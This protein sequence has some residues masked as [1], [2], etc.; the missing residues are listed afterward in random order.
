M[1]RPRGF[2]P[3]AMATHKKRRPCCEDAG[4]FG[5]DEGA[6]TLGLRLA[7]PA[8]SQLSYIPICVSLSALVITA[9]AATRL[10]WGGYSRRVVGLT[11]LELVTS[12]LSAGRS[13]QLSYRPIAGTEYTPRTA[14]GQHPILE[15]QREIWSPSRAPSIDS[16]SLL[17]AVS[18]P[19]VVRGRRGESMRHP[20]PQAG[21]RPKPQYPPHGPRNP[22][23]L[24][25]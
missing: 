8:L 7:K 19:A 24:L 22:N 5:G 6:R 21:R 9:P 17:Y 16:R 10:R 20:S 4:T 15:K 12:R 2:E 18:C 23:A 25:W 1:S 3:P 11:R 13:E 14:L